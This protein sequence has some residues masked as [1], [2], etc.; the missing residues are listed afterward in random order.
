MIFKS[1]YFNNILFAF[2]FIILLIPNCYAS[3]YSEDNAAYWYL[4]AVKLLPN[5][6][7]MIY[8]IDNLDTNVE[9]LNIESDYF[10]KI[11]NLLEKG[12]NTE[13]CFFYIMPK[14]DGDE[15]G[16]SPD[17]PFFS[18]K[19]FKAN[20]IAWYCISKGK[21][22]YA[23]VI[24]KSIIL[25]TKNIAKDNSITVRV[26]YSNPFTGVIRSL[27][28]YFEN[29]A[30]SEFKKEFIEILKKFPK[31]IFDL[32]DVKKVHYN[33]QMQNYERFSKD[34]NS[35]A[36]IFGYYKNRSNYR[37][38]KN[39]KCLEGLRSIQKRIE[40]FSVLLHLYS[41][42][43]AKYDNK[44]L[45]ANLD[46]E[47]FHYFVA[48]QDK[49]TSILDEMYYPEIIKYMA[50]TFLIF[51]DNDYVC[52]EKGYRTLDVKK[53]FYENKKKGFNYSYIWCKYSV[54]CNCKGKEV[55]IKP[56]PNTVALEKAENYKNSPTFESD[57]K[58]FKEFYEKLLA[59]DL[60]KE[61]SKMELAAF[62]RQY[63]NN[64]LLNYMSFR[65][66]GFGTLF[67]N[68][69][70]AQKSLDDFLKKYVAE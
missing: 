13:K 12:N 20:N 61:M 49:I 11:I 35:L 24:W 38:E 70:I 15:T 56:N 4:E 66:Y 59:T 29:G 62:D 5:T 9:T 47:I 6:S 40:I 50:G 41:N 17:I 34:I 16:L 26:A 7:K 57:L 65:K 31:N 22:E 46:T 67:N 27:S 52:P 14:Y 64:K 39:K 36:R 63:S 28:N 51:F 33:Y 32:N 60:S 68:I 53:D 10:K 44:T 2:L 43:L 69:K 21:T 8:S 23:S 18:Q 37:T 25:I 48:N 19:L 55:E 1:N 42:G 45:K 30:S 58:E 3:P 54:N